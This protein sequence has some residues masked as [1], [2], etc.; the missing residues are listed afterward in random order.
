MKHL[1][2]TCFFTFAISVGAI[3]SDA[4]LTKYQKWCIENAA[5]TLRTFCP[6]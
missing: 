2:M 5:D 3:Q 1:Y 4:I 6:E